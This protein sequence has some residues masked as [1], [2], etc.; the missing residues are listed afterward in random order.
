[1]KKNLLLFFCAGVLSIIFATTIFNNTKY[2]NRAVRYGLIIG[3]LLLFSHVFLYNWNYLEN[4]S[5][6]LMLLLI[7]CLLIF[8]VYRNLSDSSSTYYDNHN[9]LPA[10][11]TDIA[12]NYNDKN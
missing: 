8:Y 12:E 7:F 6:L 3:S 9:Y 10:I 5:K 2:K 1:M 11:Y 4:D